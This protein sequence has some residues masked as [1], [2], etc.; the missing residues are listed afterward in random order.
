MASV[1][2]YRADNASRLLQ[3]ADLFEGLVVHEACSILG[4]V[5]LPLL[6]VLPELPGPPSEKVIGSDETEAI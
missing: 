1:S 6:N 3:A 2:V 5:K 4:D